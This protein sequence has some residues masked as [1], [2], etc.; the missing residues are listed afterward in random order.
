VDALTRTA[1]LL[2]RV[3]VRDRRVRVLV[4]HLA[5]LLPPNAAVLDIGCGD[6]AIALALSEARPDVRV[7]GADVLVR[8]RARIEVLHFDGVRVPVPDRS[9]DVALLVDVLHHTR[10]PEALLREA[11]RVT[12]AGLL[13]KDHVEKGLLAGPTLRLMDWVGNRYEGVA[14]PYNYWRQERW[15]SAW[16]EV[17]LTVTAEITRLELN[18][19][20]LSWLFDRSLHFIVRLIPNDA[21]SREP[22]GA[23]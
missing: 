13:V 12:R 2:H 22:N 18:A 8:P 14:L 17:G 15:A 16:R 3:V 20:P 6:G 19:P 23:A 4:Q 5:P 1:G 21:A 7:T 9:F 11:L 10:A